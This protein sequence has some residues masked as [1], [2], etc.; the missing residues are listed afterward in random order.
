MLLSSNKITDLIVSDL[1]RNPSSRV[2]EMMER[3]ERLGENLTRQA[4]HR[5]LNQ[6]KDVG[7]VV[8]EGGRYSLKLSWIIS[9]RRFIKETTEKYFSRDMIK[10]VQ[11]GPGEAKE[12]RFPNLAEM[13]MFG[14]H[15][16]L[17]LFELVDDLD[18]FA[19]EPFPWYVPFAPEQEE[20]F[21]ESLKSLKKNRKVVVGG[22]SY[23]H[24]VRDGR[25]NSDAFSIIYDSEFPREKNVFEY[26]Y[27]EYLLEVVVPDRTAES[28]ET[29]FGEVSSADEF[30][31]RK[32]EK[33]AY[34]EVGD[35]ILRIWNNR[36]EAQSRRAD[37]RRIF[38]D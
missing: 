18:Y 19:W 14:C 29:F 10:Q 20:I 21:S 15:L 34:R 36:A 12:W 7:V 17:A 9:A 28:L 22:D 5:N 6:L 33:L 26:L 23:L 32:L 8:S 4:L 31:Y 37:Y 27:G 13:D 11:P 16:D 2:R 3:F 24:R 38:A 1:S 30:S 35:V 25:P